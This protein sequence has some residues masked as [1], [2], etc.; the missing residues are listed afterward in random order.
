MDSLRLDS[1]LVKFGFFE[2]RNKA[3][4]A[5]KSGDISINGKIIKKQ[6]VK[7][8]KENIKNIEIKNRKR[9][10]SRSAYKLKYYFEEFPIN[11]KNKIAIDIGSGKGGFS[12]ILLEYG[13]KSID[14][15]DVG[16]EQ[17]DKNLKKNSSINL[18][19]EV[20]IRDF[21][22]F[23][24]KYDVVV[25]DLSFISLNKIL[26]KIK[27]LTKKDSEIVLLFKPQFEVGKSA[28][29]D[30]KGVVKDVESIKSAKDKF[31]KKLKSFG[32]TIINHLPSKQLGKEGNQEYIY[33]LKR[34]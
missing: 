8:S 19:E 9:Y 5:I 18:Y 23:G 12:E 32:F 21:E 26:P 27:D 15:V 13:V 11:L 17:F 6:S 16:K 31:E 29:R 33:H 22:N 7:I 20:D 34:V 30:S 14:A 4:E 1:A 10:V 24:K 28:K 2:S 25:S 3:V